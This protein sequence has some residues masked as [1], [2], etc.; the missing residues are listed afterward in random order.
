VSV[1]G[2]AVRDAAEAVDLAGRRLL[3]FGEPAGPVGEEVLADRL[4]RDW[5]RRGGAAPHE[6]DPLPPLTGATSVGAALTGAVTRPWS[7]QTGWTVADGEAVRDGLRLRVGPEDVAGDGTLRVPTHL[8][9]LAPG[10]HLVLGARDLDGAGT[11]R[12]RRTYL[13]LRAGSACRV[14]TALVAALDAAGLPFR[15]KCL[16]GA[17]AYVRCDAGVL[18]TRAED[19]AAVGGAVDGVLATCAGALRPATPR[20]TRPRRPGVGEADDPGG[21]DSFG[22]HRC[23]LVARGLT[24]AL[25]R[26]V[27]SVDGRVAHVERVFVAAGLDPDAPHRAPR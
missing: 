18:F 13:H 15:V 22:G 2:E 7:L 6:H 20:L 5:Y 1:L 27:R 21:G 8:P 25:M 16:D 10:Y 14:V 3:W 24:D 9:H 19:D 17:H 26:R 11:T 23:R 4:Y 12:V